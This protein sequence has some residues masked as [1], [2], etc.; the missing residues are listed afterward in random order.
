MVGYFSEGTLRISAKDKVVRKIVIKK[1]FRI[2]FIIILFS[3]KSGGFISIKKVIDYTIQY[4]VCC[5][6]KYIRIG[7]RRVETD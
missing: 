7:L 6:S 4:S 5:L 2:V 1:T 3:D